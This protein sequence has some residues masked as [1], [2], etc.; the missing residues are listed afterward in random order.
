MINTFFR[1]QVDSVVSSEDTEQ[2]QE[3]SS[4]GDDLNLCPTI[5]SVQ[6]DDGVMPTEL[7]TEVASSSS[8][9]DSCEPGSGSVESTKQAA[10]SSTGSGELETAWKTLQTALGKKTGAKPVVEMVNK[11]L[12]TVVII[13][14][15]NPALFFSE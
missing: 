1:M 4:T 5:S 8:A 11:L 3:P 6:Q 10:D 2:I 12:E 9:V 14:V 13:F 15:N 7:E